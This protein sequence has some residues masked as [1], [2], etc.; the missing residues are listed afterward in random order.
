[1]K[2]GVALA[3]GVSLLF[4][5]C[6]FPGWKA[7]F[8]LCPLVWCCFLALSFPFGL[9]LSLPLCGL[10]F[11]LPLCVFGFGWGFIWCGIAGFGSLLGVGFILGL[12]GKMRR[13][14]WWRSAYLKNKMKI[15]NITMNE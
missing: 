4:A 8:A 12:V 9:V 5:L 7:F 3:D 13:F 1:M 6:P 14:I 15:I 11:A 2:T 10:L